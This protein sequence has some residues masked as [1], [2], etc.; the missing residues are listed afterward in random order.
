MTK[1]RLNDL[2]ITIPT[3]KRKWPNF[4]QLVRQC[5]NLTF[6]VFVREND[7]NNGYYNEPQ[8][9]LP[10]IKFVLLNDVHELGETR[11]RML[12]YAINNNYKYNLQMDDSQYGLQDTTGKIN[13]FD[14]ILLNCINR[15]ET[16]IYKDKA[17]AFNF[18][19]K[20]YSNNIKKQ[21]TYFLSQ[22]CQT[23]ILNCEICKQY[24]LHFHCL[25]YCGLEDLSFIIHAVNK[26]LIE[27][28]DTRFIK[29]G[30]APCLPSSK[31]GCHDCNYKE[32]N[33]KRVEGIYNYVMSTD[34]IIDKNFL[35]KVDSI[36]YPETYYY[37]FN[38]KYAKKKLL[39]IENDKIK[40]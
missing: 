1:D 37:K 34:N 13:Y 32:L 6:H 15:F 20:A 11:E 39:H 17:F 23:F 5:D 7:Y 26:G 2:C 31:G 3:Y 19:R 9:D 14:S 10:N 36:L 18:A 4:L 38:T 29:T 35:Q 8:F 40:Y 33:R 12:Q 24:D 27:L 22:F 21:K 28:S 30:T 25:D 16:D